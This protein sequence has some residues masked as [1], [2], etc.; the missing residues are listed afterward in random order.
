MVPK[1]YGAA[2]TEFT[3]EGLGR[4]TECTSCHVKEVRNGEYECEFVYPV[5]GHLFGSIEEGSYIA[6][7][8]DD[9]K[10]VQPFKIYRRSAP[11][12]GR[13][14]F[15]AR[16]ISYLLNH[17][18]VAPFEANSAVEAMAALKNSAVNN[19][20]FTFL[21][22]KTTI[23]TM[24]TDEPKAVRQILGGEGG[25]LDVYG[26][27]E[28]DF[29]LW[30]VAFKAHRG[31]ASGVQIR[32]GKNLIDLDQEKDAGETYNAVVPFWRG[33]VDEVEKLVTVTGYIVAASGVS[34]VIPVVLDLSGEFDDEPTEAELRHA[35]EDYL[36]NTMPWLAHESIKVNFAQLWQTA[37]YE[38]R[39]NLQRLRLCDTVS[40]YYPALGVTADGIKIVSVDYD[41]LSEKYI[42]MEL[43]QV[44]TRFE[45]IVATTDQMQSALQ[46]AKEDT[47]SFMDAA[48]SAATKLIT[49]ASGGHIVIGTNADGQPEEI[50][51]MDTESILTATN[52]LRMNLNGIGFSTDGGQTYSTAWTIDGRFVADFITAGKLKAITIEGPT[53][54]TFWDLA[55]GVW[56][57]YGTRQ[58]STTIYPVTGSPTV[59]SYTAQEKTNIDAGVLSVIGK[60]E[61]DPDTKETTFTSLGVR[62]T[63][64]VRERY[65]GDPS[66]LSNDTLAYPHGGVLSR[67]YRVEAYGG[68][69][70]ILAENKVTAEY[71]PLS[72]LTPDRL[73]LGKADNPAYSSGT[74]NAPDRNVLQVNGGWVNKENAILFFRYCNPY[75]RYSI[76][77][78]GSGTWEDHI[79]FDP[80]PTNNPSSVAWDLAPGD[81][82]DI[83]NGDDPVVYCMGT[84]ING[85]KEIVFQLPL[86]RPVSPYS[87]YIHIDGTIHARQG[88]TVLCNN[89]IFD[90]R[91]ENG[92]HYFSLI[93]ATDCGLALKLHHWGTGSWSTGTLYTPVF[94]TLSYM[95][96][97]V[98]YEDENPPEGDPT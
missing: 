75:Q 55:T 52:I 48:V 64:A 7:I 94:I 88:S 23:G 85:K 3:S 54:L 71:N 56:Q 74:N 98:L 33:T 19:N 45:S 14:T 72:I 20:P 16:H 26:G 34:T 35:A 18:I 80:W 40:V 47:H 41:V 51:I 65:P 96:I 27:G 2:E 39:A 70:D 79:M 11:I 57:S 38:D 21:T 73:E 17:V 91:I 97:K 30:H 12:D 78:E 8:H 44:A 10:D 42:S 25:I 43:G 90:S 68:S 83:T 22:D 89:D 32:Y 1:L 36:A 61:T 49:G 76:D 24:T 9:D 46:R 92:A 53:P 63:D 81:E 31:N 93:R 69:G 50:L 29:D 28:F 13:V 5:T 86:S 4:L 77:E 59:I 6:C 66:A 87:I 37:E 60:K 62:T 95:S 15:N 82:I 67:G 84:L 58:L